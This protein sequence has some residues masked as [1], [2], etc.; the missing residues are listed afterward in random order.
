MNVRANLQILATV[1]LLGTLLWGAGGQA[2]ESPPLEAVDAIESQIGQIEELYLVPAVLESRYRVETRFNDAKVAYLMGEYPRA[3]LLFVAVV[4]SSNVRQFDSY[5]EAL[6]LLGDSLYKQRSFRAGRQYFRQVVDLGEGPF[7]Q[8]A[9]VRLLEI[10]AETGDYS[11]VDQLYARLDNLES[12]G[13]AI[14]YIRGK[15]LY[16]E[17]RM[18]AARPWFQRAARDE[19]Y[20]FTARYFEAVTLVAEGDLNGAEEIFS[21]LTRQAP[22][23]TDDRKVVDLANLALGRLAYENDRFDDA[24][25]FY[26]Q[27]PR[28]STYFGRALYELTWALVAR[29][30]YRSALRNL[31]ILLISDPDPKFVPEARALMADLAMR[32]QEYEDARRWF[33]ELVST[34]TPVR[35]ELQRFIDE[36]EDLE[37]FFVGM[38]RDELEGVRA[39]FLPPLVS[40]WVDDKGMMQ[41]SRLLMENGI[42]TQDDIDEAYRAIEEVEQM[43]GFGSSIEAFPALAEG[44]S[45]G[46]ELEGRLVDLQHALLDWELRQIQPLLG[47]A[48]YDRIARIE[49]ELAILMEREA[50]TPRTREDLRARDL[51]IR[52]RFRGLRT[53]VDRIAFEISGMED[54]LEGISTYLTQDLSGFSEDEKGQIRSIRDGLRAD[55]DRL[56]EARLQLSRELDQTQREFGTR[57]ESLT[58]QRE[59]RD[60]IQVLQEERAEIV[61]AQSSYLQANDQ[62]EALRAAEARRRLP[63]MKLRLDR[64]FSEIDRLVEERMEDIR[65]T[66]ESERVQLAAYQA[67][68]DG[69]VDETEGAVV[70]IAVWHFRGVEREFDE[71]VGRGHVGS[72]DVDW[73]R[74]ED[75]RREREDLMDEKA[76]TERMLR[77]AFPDAR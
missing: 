29:E 30:S 43:L 16:D 14:H 57:D 76:S 35:A 74:L 77:E 21:R 59:L 53:E 25:D 73:Q 24:V 6:F 70:S 45:I 54:T 7:Y 23:G 22:T 1:G 5:R 18:R 44:W 49:S 26:L 13:A 8:S 34:F 12:V 41:N 15:T 40:E 31:E 58:R 60:K 4:D 61:D 2:Q 3:A 67:E 63:G 65:N 71:L 39:E 62:L 11:E 68:L 48:D 9:I 75:A 64:Y 46:V 66:I 37:D 19:K 27:V 56:E 69:W 52:S 51:E 42:I 47:P 20:S 33:G 32:L 28:T 50:R 38:V 55:L 72:V 10:A 17:G 36:Q